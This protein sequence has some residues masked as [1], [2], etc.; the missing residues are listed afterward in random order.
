MLGQAA[1]SSEGFFT[2][3]LDRSDTLWKAAAASV[4]YI[5]AYAPLALFV[6]ALAARTSFSAGIFVGGIFI[7]NAV[8]T[9]LVDSD[10][11]V[12]GLLAINHHPRYV[13]D[14]IFDQ[15]SH[16]WI[17]QRAGFDPWV[18]I[19]VIVVVAV[20]AAYLVVRRYRRLM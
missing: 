15:T 13:T 1:V 4:V 17:P 16:R 14:W 3:L 18:S 6:A 9:A 20:A 5:A 10:F 7:G 11:P 8:S 2:D 12:F 19:V